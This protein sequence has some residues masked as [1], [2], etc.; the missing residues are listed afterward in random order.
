MS[1]AHGLEVRVPLID[2]RLAQR[3]LLCRDRGSWMRQLRN[4]CSSGRSPVNFRRRSS[5]DGSAV[6]LCPSNT[7]C[8]RLA[9]H[10]RRQFEQDQRWRTWYDD[11]PISGTSSMGRFFAGSNFLD[12]PVVV[13]RAAKLVRAAHFGLNDSQQATNN[14]QRLTMQKVEEVRNVANAVRSWQTAGQRDHSGAQRGEESAAMSAGAERRWA[15]SIVIDS[16]STDETVEIARSYGA[17]VVQFHYQGGWPK[18]RQWA[19]DTL[20]LAYD[21]ILLLDADEMLTPESRRRNSSSDPK[22]GD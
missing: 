10:C 9:S 4:L 16:Q 21:W 11:Q 7:G 3:M 2:H 22:S 18:K 6:L 13:V 17:Q 15:K 8:G 12:A 19:M 20:P 5:I 1:M 14:E